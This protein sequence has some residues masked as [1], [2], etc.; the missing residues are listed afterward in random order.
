[1]LVKADPAKGIEA[2]SIATAP[3]AGSRDLAVVVAV[4]QN[5]LA[6]RVTAGENRGERLAH[7][8]VVR[9]FA[10]H[11]GLGRATASFRPA[12][13]WNLARMSVAAFVQD[14][15]SGQVL[16]AVACALPG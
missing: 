2:T 5:G 9:D 4:S 12:P 10:V 14:R 15:K 16:Q 1:V 8:F 6:S 11:A 3:D 7:D 13:G